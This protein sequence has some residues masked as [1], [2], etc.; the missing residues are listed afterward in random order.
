MAKTELGRLIET[1][2]KDILVSAI[3]IPANLQSFLTKANQGELEVKG[4]AESVNLIY[5]LGHQL[6]YGLF[7]MFFG[8]CGYFAYVNGE[9][10]FSKGC[11]LSVPFS[12]YVWDTLPAC[13]QN[14]KKIRA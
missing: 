10:V 1:A 7:A 6:L 2:I 3:T 12:C 14:G 4:L 13:S 9:D 8:G 11:F 5:A